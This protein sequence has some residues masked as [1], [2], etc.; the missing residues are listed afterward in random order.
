VAAPRGPRQRSGENG[1]SLLKRWVRVWLLSTLFLVML[2]AGAQAGPAEGDAF[3]VEEGGQQHDLVWNQHGRAH[4]L[5]RPDSRLVVAFPADNVGVSL[6]FGQGSHLVVA[7][8]PQ[9]K[10][11]AQGQRL[12]VVLRS[13]KPTLR[14]SDVVLDS[15][16]TIRD[17]QTSG[18]PGVEVVRRDRQAFA[19]RHPVPAN[20]AREAVHLAP[21]RWT[22]E[23]V[24]LD[25]GAYRAV[26]EF[27]R[28]VRV[29]SLGEGWELAGD[30]PFEVR[31][32]AE[33]PPAPQEG[34]SLEEL[35][36]A[37]A[38]ALREDPAA[39]AAMRGL[40]FLAPR[41]K[42]MAGSWRFLTYFGRDT[43]L[44][45]ML[46]DP[47]LTEEAWQRGLRSVLVRLSSTGEVAHEEDLGPWAERRRV[48]GELEG[49]DLPEAG[50][51][52]SGEV[53]EAFYAPLYDYKMVD[54]DFL[55]APALARLGERSP[56]ALQS[57]LADP[58]ARQGVL[59]NWRYVL[60]SAGPYALDPS[61][62]RTIPLQ[63]G[64]SVGD[65]R[66]SNEGLGGGRY[67]MNVNALLVPAA[68]RAVA[69][70]LEM[71]PEGS[72][73]ACLAEL[74]I[75]AARA[76]HLARAWDRAAG[77]Y[78]VHLSVAEVRTR[79]RRFLDEGPLVPAERAFYLS[80][81]LASG[82]S[83]G[84]FLEGG[85]ALALK[86]GLEF[87]ALSLDDQGRPLAIMNSDISFELFLGQPSAHQVEMA[88]RLLELPYPVGLRT[89]VGPVVANAA[90]ITDPGHW[91]TLGRGAYHGAVVWSWQTAMLRSGL[92]RLI[93]VFR[94]PRPDLARRMQAVLADL[95]QTQRAAG[96]M[97]GSE[98]WTFEVDSGRWGAV[99]YGTGTATS[100][101][102]SNP[103]QL[104][105]TVLPALILREQAV[106][107]EGR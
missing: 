84:Q 50:Q 48:A 78:R 87:P 102:E 66:D 4:L 80:Q 90:Y 88:L 94:G 17:R 11:A 18:P 58:Q 35:F 65:W 97:G 47:A 63:A 81:P 37:E 21:G 98:L 54:D 103:V 6:W 7:S 25:G 104:W 24:D 91:K 57:L 52:L 29:R 99:P 60:D 32:T 83:L 106:L 101:D 33:V 20:W 30:A 28:E 62:R 1:S 19:E 69:R 67:A 105:S 96:E 72:R 100:G 74:P 53:I 42:F 2:P 39:R 79:L 40:H 16:R 70:S 44:S 22:A 85:A 77:D 41:E 27:P 15:I 46:L 10:P 23:R 8:P 89:G 45:L 43:L 3:T 71:L 92:A 75:S 51:P 34:C 12:E 13:H 107:G 55:L 38:L 95:R 64:Q 36:T 56:A 9:L 82:L 31:L 14:L 5:V 68:L 76:E 86:E 93:P 73:A 61:W 59:R 49:I 26:L